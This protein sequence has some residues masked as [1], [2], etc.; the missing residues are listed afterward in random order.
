MLAAVVAAPLADMTESE[1]FEV[2]LKLREA[3][4]FEMMQFRRAGQRDMFAGAFD[5]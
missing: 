1:A 4:Y 5:A 3:I 2:S